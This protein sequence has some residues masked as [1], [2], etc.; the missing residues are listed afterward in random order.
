MVMRGNAP[1]PRRTWRLA[2]D[3]FGRIG[4]SFAH[5]VYL[6]ELRGLC[7]QLEQALSD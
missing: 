1:E 4:G 5:G 7:D 6:E 3:N 2:V